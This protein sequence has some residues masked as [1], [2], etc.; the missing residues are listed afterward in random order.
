MAVLAL[1]I[2]TALVTIIRLGIR[3][4]ARNLGLDDAF[5]ASSLAGFLVLY[6]GLFLHLDRQRMP[7]PYRHTPTV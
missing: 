4:R 2:P 7:A 5:A 3:A 6:V 1:A